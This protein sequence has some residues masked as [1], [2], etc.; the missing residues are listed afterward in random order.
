MP[1]SIDAVSTEL[2]KV[3][4]KDIDTD[5]II[6]KLQPKLQ[7]AIEKALE[8]DIKKYLTP[9]RY[10]EGAFSGVIYKV[11]ESKDVQRKLEGMVYEM[12]GMKQPPEKKKK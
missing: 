2:I 4:L 1:T 7:A 8:D 10:D 3:M 6:K 5:T 12:F 9:N 11:M